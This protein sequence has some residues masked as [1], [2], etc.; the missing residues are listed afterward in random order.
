[1]CAQNAR[2]SVFYSKYV[3]CLIRSGSF[4]KT[5]TWKKS[6]F[7][8]EFEFEFEFESESDEKYDIIKYTFIS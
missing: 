3:Y 5:K 1:M 6:F 7:S 2:H 8:F 4:L